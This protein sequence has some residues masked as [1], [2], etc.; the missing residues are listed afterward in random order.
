MM[1]P[2][3]RKAEIAFHTLQPPDM[4]QV[5]RSIEILDLYPHEYLLADKVK[6]LPDS[7][8]LFIM[9]ADPDI[10]IIFRMD[11]TDKEVTDIVRYGRLKKMFG[12]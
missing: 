2:L 4:K 7:D 8:D 10:I 6:K 9:K 11:D 12:K 5:Q 3:S 1:I